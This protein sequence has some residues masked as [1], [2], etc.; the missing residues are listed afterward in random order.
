M[1]NFATAL[2]ICGS[3]LEAPAQ[4]ALPS[5]AP[6]A[7]PVDITAEYLDRLVAAAESANP[8]LRAARSRAASAALGVESV[9]SWDDPMATFGGSVFSPIGMDPAQIG[10][11]AYGV[12]QKLPLWG[13]PGLNRAVAESDVA[14]RQS[15]AALRLRELRRDVAKSLLAAALAERAIALGEQ[16]LAWLRVTALAAENK[17]RAGEPALADTLQAQ[18]EIAV[19][20][21]TLLND[22]HRLDHEYVGLNRLLNRPPDSSWPSLRLPP[23]G[24]AIPF[25]EKLF[26]L[27]LANEP[28][29]RL[30]E[31]QVRQ[32]RA[33]AEL[34]RKSRLPEVSLG[35]EGRQYS[36]DGRFRE[37]DFMIRFSLPWFNAGKYNK[38]YERDQERQATAEHERQDRMLMVREE[39][40]RLSL[41]VDALRRESLLYSDEIMVR[42]SQVL[43]SRLADWEAGRG[44]FRDVLDA[45][46]ALLDSELMS[47]RAAAEENQMLA[48][49]LLW[50]G[51][52]D[53]NAL[54]ALAHEPA[55]SSSHE[56]HTPPHE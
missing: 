13:R 53:M 2:L 22:H 30:M 18:N 40:H 4:D 52:D 29:V 50:S 7:A 45:R 42:A 49:M 21:N 15:E 26:A 35:V 36:G 5:A 43:A 48:E 8:G 16:D 9:R 23:L 14:M 34:T 20:N 47:A 56:A 12:E 33:A 28:G 38:D 54:A 1:K 24:P 25:S 10:D 6:A 32:A 44:A 27:A 17:Y 39:L 55:Q 46:R 3:L 19:R 31:Q 11:L 51:L 37:G 41:D